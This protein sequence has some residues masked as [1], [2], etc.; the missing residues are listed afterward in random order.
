MV[1]LRDSSEVGS[2][3]ENVA[4]WVQLLLREGTAATRKKKF[5]WG[6]A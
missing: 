4:H 1:S 3:A 2:S 6:A 5:C